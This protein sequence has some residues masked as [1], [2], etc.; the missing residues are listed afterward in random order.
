MW[1][2]YHPPPKIFLFKQVNNWGR[3]VFITVM[4]NVQ[5]KKKL[6][7]CIRVFEY[8]N[9]ITMVN[10]RLC[11]IYERG[12]FEQHPQTLKEDSESDP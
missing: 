9:L 6:Y 5:S 7:N 10:L 2:I 4:Y 1:E 8:L 3:N 12:E 11:G